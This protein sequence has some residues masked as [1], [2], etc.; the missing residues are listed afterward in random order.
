VTGIIAVPGTVLIIGGQFDL[1]VGSAAAACGI[2]MA[3]VGA[4]HGLA[5][6]VVASL[7]TG[8]LVGVINGVLVTVVGVNALI[9]TLGMLSV[10]GGLAEI[11]AGGQTKILGGFS[12]LGTTRPFADIPTPVIIYVCVAIAGALLMRYTIFGRSVYAIGSNP[13][14]ARL[15]GVRARKIMLITFVASGVAA[16]LGGLILTSQL[17]AASPTSAAG[18]ELSVLTAIV[19]GG[20]SLTGG[21]GS[22]LGTFIGLAIIGV[23]NNGLVLLN[24]SSFYQDVAR[25]SL[26]IVAVSFDQLRQHFSKTI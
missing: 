6:G 19:L 2:V 14:A 18:M 7:V 20:A 9:T 17:G 16:A 11:W 13:S 26:L 25:G 23:L 22:I 10:L 15:V 24:V 4:Q 8:A 21:R 5:L 1:S 3:T 12:T